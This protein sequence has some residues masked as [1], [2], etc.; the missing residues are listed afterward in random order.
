MQ[1]KY[2]DIYG[3]QKYIILSGEWGPMDMLMKALGA[4]PMHIANVHCKCNL[5]EAVIVLVI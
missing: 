4:F 1:K 5:K 3:G 2:T